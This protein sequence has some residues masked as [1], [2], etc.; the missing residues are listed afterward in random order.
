M[1][2]PGP[3][4][5]WT[6]PRARFIA[7]AANRS[8]AESGNGGGRAP[9]EMIGLTNS[10]RS[11]AGHRSSA[12]VGSAQEAVFGDLDL[13]AAASS[14]DEELVASVMPLVPPT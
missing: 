12:T 7:A 9:A 5:A 10:T 13:I 11:G 4:S 6:D 14:H 8:Q 3:Q 1:S 2:W